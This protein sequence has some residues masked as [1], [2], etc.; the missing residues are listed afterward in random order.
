MDK[1]LWVVSCFFPHPKNPDP[2]KMGYFEDL[3]KIHPWLR[4]KP[5]PFLRVW[6]ILRAVRVFDQASLVGIGIGTEVGLFWRKES[7]EGS[8]RH[9]Q[10]DSQPKITQFPKFYFFQIVNSENLRYSQGRKPIHR[11]ELIGCTPWVVKFLS[12][13]SRAVHK[14]HPKSGQQA[15][16]LTLIFFGPISTA[17]QRSTYSCFF[18]KKFSE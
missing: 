18:L 13:N 11:P 2:S 1:T 15:D 7:K 6:G 8:S 12:A 16:K 4:F 10:T 17:Q 3:Y 14:T 5:L 9:L